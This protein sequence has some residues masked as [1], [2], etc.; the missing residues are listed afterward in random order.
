MSVTLRAPRRQLC[1]VDPAA[2]LPMA[3]R[4]PAQPAVRSAR[5]R[6]W[7]AR[8]GAAGSVR[9]R[10]L[11]ETAWAFA[12]SVRY[13]PVITL[14]Y[15]FIDFIFCN[16]GERFVSFVIFLK[17]KY[18][19]FTSSIALEWFN[20]RWLLKLACRL[21]A[22]RALCLWPSCGPGGKGTCQLSAGC[23]GVTSLVRKHRFFPNSFLPE[24]KNSVKY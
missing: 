23:L 3:G 2:P 15:W 6:L 21:P 7:R 12:T 22:R 9:A 19:Y 1:A 20:S 10:T 17:N 14:E 18:M 13:F 4:S 11:L 5:L 8:P 24:E 16:S